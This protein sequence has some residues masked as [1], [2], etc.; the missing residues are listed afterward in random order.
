MKSCRLCLEAVIVYNDANVAEVTHL[1][2]KMIDLLMCKM[3]EIS[4]VLMY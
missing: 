4:F 3:T 1:N 2:F